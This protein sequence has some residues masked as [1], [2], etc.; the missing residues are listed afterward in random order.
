MWWHATEEKLQENGYS[1][2][3]MQRY[4]KQTA[5]PETHTR[6]DTSFY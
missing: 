4:D 5:I 2:P 6:F 3:E 1:L